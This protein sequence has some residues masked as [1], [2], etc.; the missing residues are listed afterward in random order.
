MTSILGTIHSFEIKSQI[1]PEWL[2][3]HGVLLTSVSVTVLVCFSWLYLIISIIVRF[4]SPA[5]NG[6]QGRSVLAGMASHFGI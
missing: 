4:G 2:N 5:Y 1:I 6:F 3:I